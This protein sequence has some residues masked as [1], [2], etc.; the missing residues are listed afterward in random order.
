MLSV[1]TA[2][3]NQLPMNRLFLK[4]LQQFTH[5]PFELIVID[6]GSTD[7]SGHFFKKQG[8]VVIRN[9]Q[10]MAYPATQNQG[11][12]AATGDYFVFMNND[13][14]VGPQWDKRLLECMS[15]GKVDIIS[16]ASIDR[17]ESKLATVQ[18]RRKWKQ[19]R[20]LTA[21]LGY[22]EYAMNFRKRL[23]YGNWEHFCERRWND[24]G[25]QLL[26]GF[27]GHT[28]MMHRATFEKVGAWD[29]RILQADFDLYLRSRQR[30]ELIGDLRPIALA[31]GVFVHHYGRLTMRRYPNAWVPTQPIVEIED[32]WG[33]QAFLEKTAHLDLHR[34]FIS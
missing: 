17:A 34:E 15:H 24:Y 20:Y 8:C 27:S 11:V 28:L 9:E 4:R 3:H 2:V 26:E 16:P 10:N 1:I 14:L 22:G 31:T 19:I 13:V 23:L 12:A 25:T 33:D 21:A 18:W 29:E 32:K 30:W 7:G 5:F 6:N